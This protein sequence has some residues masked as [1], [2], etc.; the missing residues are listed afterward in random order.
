MMRACFTS[1]LVVSLFCVA[2]TA[3]I[4]AQTPSLKA[5]GKGSRPAF[6]RNRL[7]SPLTVTCGSGTNNWTGT[8]GNNQWA[9]ASNWST[10]A[11]PVSTDTVCIAS[12]F[13]TITIGS[14]AAGNQTIARDSDRATDDHL[15]NTE[16]FDGQEDFGHHAD[17]KRR[18][19]D[20]DR[21]G[22]DHRGADLVGRN[23]KR[24]RSHGC[25]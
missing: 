11:V 23:G 8:A 16:L 15:R 9:T 12:T 20:R 22:D 19:A 18:D 4:F 6:S 1:R 24:N 14:L 5:H 17:A 21:H 25:Q 7:A 10:G 13:T 3:T 2:F